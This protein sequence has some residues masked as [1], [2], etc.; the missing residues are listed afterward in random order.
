M[1][2]SLLDMETAKIV[3]FRSRKSGID[4]DAYN[5]T[6]AEMTQ[7]VAAIPGY[8]SHKTFHHADG[9]TVTLGEFDSLDAVTAWRNHPSHRAAQ[10]MGRQ[11]WYESYELT[12]CDIH[13]RR[14]FSREEATQ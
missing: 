4:P 7:L 6:A 11:H 1:K 2:G 12:I 14:T 3:I 13:S 8:I 9:E 10:E 5:Q